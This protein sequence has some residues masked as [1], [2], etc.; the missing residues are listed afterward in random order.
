MHLKM[1]SAKL[2][3]FCHG[4]NMLISWE[5]KRGLNTCISFHCI[6]GKMT[7]KLCLNEPQEYVTILESAEMQ[8]HQKLVRYCQSRSVLEIPRGPAVWGRQLWRRTRN[9]L[10]IFLQFYIDHLRFKLWGPTTFL[11]WVSNTGSNDHQHDQVQN[12]VSP[13]DILPV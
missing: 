5:Y 11:T 4:L 12:I 13:M 2:W 10:L 6:S 7:F 9:F 3:Q 1:L 8:S